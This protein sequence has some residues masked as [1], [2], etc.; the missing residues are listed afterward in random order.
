MFETESFVDSNCKQLAVLCEV[1]AADS[2][3][4][5]YASFKIN[6]G[7]FFHASSDWGLVLRWVYF[8]SFV[9][10]VSCMKKEII[11]LTPI[12]IYM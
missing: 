10:L 5:S 4:C 2:W 3:I 11:I 7:P 1:L 12:H 8:F 6:L 9:I